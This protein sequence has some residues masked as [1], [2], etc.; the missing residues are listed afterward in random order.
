MIVRPFLPLR[1][2]S[3]WYMTACGLGGAGRKR[4]SDYGR[5]SRFIAWNLRD[6]RNSAKMKISR[7]ALNRRDWISPV[8]RRRYAPQNGAKRRFSRPPGAIFRSPNPTKLVQ[9]CSKCAA[10]EKNTCFRDILSKNVAI[11][12]IEQLFPL[13]VKLIISEIKKFSKA[14]DIVWAQEE[15][16]NMGAWTF[17]RD[18]LDSVLSEINHPCIQSKYVGRVEAASPATGLMKK[19]I[20]E[21]SAL[22]DEALTIPKS[23]LQRRAISTNVPTKKNTQKPKKKPVVKIAAKAPPRRRPS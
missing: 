17:I 6:R 22:V 21:Q 10:G 2:H 23:K 16:R 19:H 4:L 13:P 18:R 3:A 9:W 5:K 1:H 7:V 11:V 20:A 8:G 15:P 12:R 14:E